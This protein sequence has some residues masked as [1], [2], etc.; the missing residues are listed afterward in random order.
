MKNKKLSRDEE[1]DL[2]VEKLKKTPNDLRK[3]A[4][5]EDFKR[6]I[7]YLAKELSDDI[8][9]DVLDQLKSMKI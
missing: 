3:E 8:D 1:A 9:K 5:R 7:E 6:T 4:I 2:I